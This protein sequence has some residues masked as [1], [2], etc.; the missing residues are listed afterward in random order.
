M[1]ELFPVS[2]LVRRMLKDRGVAEWLDVITTLERYKFLPREKI[3]KILREQEETEIYES[4]DVI[5]SPKE[6][7]WELEE[8]RKLEK[9]FDVLVDVVSSNYA[10][11]IV[12]LGS[13]ESIERVT[14]NIPFVKYDI[15][16]VTPVNF[17]ELK[18]EVFVDWDYLLLYYRLVLEALDLSATDVHLGVRHV[19]MVPTYYCAFR[20]NN[21]V[22]DC[23]LFD[24]TQE[25]NKRLITTLIERESLAHTADVEK[26][27]G[28]VTSV[29][30]LFGDG[31]VAL[32]VTAERVVK[33]YKCVARIQRM[34]TVSF[35]IED[36]GFSKE[37]QDDL[38]P[39]AK[40]GGGITLITGK[41][42]SGKNVTAF[43]IANAMEG[44][45]KAIA[46]YSSPIEV[47][48]P[49]PQVDYGGSS[50]A[51]SHKVRLCKKLDTDVVFLNE[52]PDKE[53]ASGV[54]DLAN[55]SVHVVTTIHLNRIWQLP[56]KLY[57]YYGDDY[58]N[59]LT[60]LNICV[61]QKMFIKQCPHCQNKASV[62]S[63]E[64]NYREL[65]EKYGV[66]F[67]YNSHGCDNC[68]NGRLKNGLQPYVE[69]IV[70]TDDLRSE[71]L[72]LDKPYEM[73]A[74]LKEY[75]RSRNL[76]L[77]YE[78][79]NAISLGKLKVEELDSIL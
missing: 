28:V 2:P 64:K 24:M 52:I 40:K 79:S 23:K 8:V 9:R 42:R 77:E 71:L 25:M 17:A 75:V 62:T 73:E 76:T 49:F 7:S 59:L 39:L 78:L 45:H 69:R 43:A 27:N 15:V 57:E 30:D 44:M 35:K 53:V 33:G 22:L 51:L 36:L 66:Q 70:F 41:P 55:S 37:I 68:I 3:I 29:T 6:G 32:R 31:Q 74:L 1:L 5:T 60:H 58:K 21:D 34:S 54:L 13:K 18:N 67:Y 50:E 56:H 14:L 46:D 63:L 20:V 48:M 72:K 16:W 19:K 12:P 47:L 26:M 11:V 65:L 61:N 4:V 38:R 10:R